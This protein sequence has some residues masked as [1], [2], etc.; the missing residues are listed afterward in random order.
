MKL[1]FRKLWLW[2]K[3]YAVWIAMA[4][5]IVWPVS[6][7]SSLYWEIKYRDSSTYVLNTDQVILNVL[8]EWHTAALFDMYRSRE[9]CEYY[10]SILSSRYDGADTEYPILSDDCLEIQTEGEQIEE[11]IKMYEI[12][13]HEDIQHILTTLYMD[14]DRLPDSVREK[15]GSIDG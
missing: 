4:Q 1:S 3:K 11:W 7:A 14:N 5:A 13:E 8:R 9:T 2:L 12:S 10:E 15:F 6:I